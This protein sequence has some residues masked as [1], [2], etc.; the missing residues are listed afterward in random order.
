MRWEAEPL[1]AARP[2][3]RVLGVRS[4]VSGPCGNTPAE[5][6]WLEVMLQNASRLESIL[7]LE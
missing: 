3:P 5:G 2:R 6:D 7:A 1:A 4:G